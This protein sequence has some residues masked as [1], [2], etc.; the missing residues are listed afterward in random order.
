MGRFTNRLVQLLRYRMVCSS[1]NRDY[2]LFHIS[3]KKAKT[4]WFNLD[5]HVPMIIRHYI[6]CNKAIDDRYEFFLCSQIYF[7]HKRTI[8]TRSS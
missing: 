8:L 6:T 7:M 2:S 4:E 3:T 5:K 1:L